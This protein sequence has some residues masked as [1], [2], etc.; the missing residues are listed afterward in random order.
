MPKIVFI[1]GV[2]MQR[3]VRSLEADLGEEQV[4]YTILEVRALSGHL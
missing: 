3:L 4:S 1:L 2:A